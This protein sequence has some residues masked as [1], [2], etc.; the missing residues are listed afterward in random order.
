MGAVAV[1]AQRFA[2][3][4][5]IEHTVFALPYAYVGAILAVSGWP[6]L[7]GMLWITVAMVGARSFA[8]AANRLIDAAID[9]RNPRTATR[10]LPAGLLSRTQVIAFALASLAV[11]LVAVWQLDPVTHWLWP[12]VIVPMVIYPYLKRVT[13]LCH[14]WLGLVDGLAPIGAWA[15]LTGH[16]PLAAWLLGGAVALWIAGFDVI[17]ATFDLEIDRAQGLHSL[18]VDIGLA[19][20]LTVV[21]VAHLA[22]VGLLVAVGLNLS[23]GPAYYVGV[24]IVALLLAYEN[25]I[26][27]PDDLSRVDA[28]FFSVNGAIAVLYLAAVALDAAIA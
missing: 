16:V 12:F 2:S 7:R 5:K 14:L 15:A 8:M 3:L 25:S 28:A 27:H 6:G 19:R 26:V 17:Y 21:R 18:P 13:P 1:P 10:E 9:A 24:A 20:A 23:L 11:F 4:V 22:T